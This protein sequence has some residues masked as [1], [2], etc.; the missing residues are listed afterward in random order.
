MNTFG[1]RYRTTIF[2]SSHGPV[3][4]CVVD[5]CPAGFV[6]L[7]ERIQKQLDRRRPGTSGASSS[8]KE[9]DRLTILS[10]IVDNRTTDGPIAAIVNN[11]DVDSKP[12]EVFKT[13]PRPGHADY[14]AAVKYGGFNDY[15]GG[16]MFSGR[17]TIPLVIS[18]GIAMQILEKKG[19]H[20]AAHSLRIGRIW[21]KSTPPV[22]NIERIARKND[23]GCADPETAK[24]MKAE[25]LDAKSEGDSVGG[26]VECIAIGLPV[27]VGEPFFNSMESVLSHLLFSVPAVKGVEIGA[28]FRV[29]E[30]K[31]SDNNDAFR[32]KNGRVVTETNN[33]GGVLGGLANGMPLLLRV[34][35]KPTPSIAKVQDSVNLKSMKETT[36]EIAGRHDPCIVPRAVP[37]MESVVAMGILDLMLVGGFI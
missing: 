15:R 22:S 19:I 3:V 21:A 13:I 31:G 12:Y 9:R 25:I 4:G 32:L 24:L 28:G 10:G 30:M 1:T 20:V 26:I 8:R 5:G 16:G 34:A 35:I 17:M 33:A 23:V 11:K 6:M 7:T 2:G 37:V 18:G 27:G 14:T 29:S 36:L